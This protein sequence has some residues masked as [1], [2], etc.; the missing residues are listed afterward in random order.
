[1]LNI[2]VDNIL[3]WCHLCKLYQY[4][5]FFLQNIFAYFKICVIIMDI[6]IESRTKS[7]IKHLFCRHLNF[8]LV[9]NIKKKYENVDPM[10]C[11]K[12]E[13]AFLYLV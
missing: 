4:C 7:N 12:M 2:L 9:Q 10:K 3:Q 6:S 11:S 8:K 5:Q 13:L 1:M